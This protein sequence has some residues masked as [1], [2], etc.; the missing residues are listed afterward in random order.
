MLP[1][2]TFMFCPN[3]SCEDRNTRKGADEVSQFFV[4]FST[5]L[6]DIQHR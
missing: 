5:D 4:P 1:V 6:Y 3:R 2:I